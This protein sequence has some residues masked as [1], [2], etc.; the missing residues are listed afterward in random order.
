MMRGKTKVQGLR[1]LGSK[2][3]GPGV[4]VSVFRCQGVRNKMVSGVSVQVSVDRR[5]WA[6][7]QISTDEI[8][9]VG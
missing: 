1:V 7:Q 6:I 9:Y 8:P 5:H 4:Q 3:Q 2:V